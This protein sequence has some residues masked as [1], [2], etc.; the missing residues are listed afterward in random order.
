H[1]ERQPKNLCCFH[2]PTPQLSK[3]TRNDEPVSLGLAVGVT[4]Y[5]R[6]HQQILRTAWF[7]NRIVTTYAQPFCRPK[8]FMTQGRVIEIVTFT[9][10][11]PNSIQSNHGVFVENRLRHLVAGAPVASRVVAPVPWFPFSW[12]VFGTY[13]DYAKVPREELRA[14][15]RIDHPRY[16]V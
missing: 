15:L 2:L 9:T 13:A 6:N 16:T 5:S 3:H 1:K 4:K 7:Y 8:I 12:D 11:F 14:G 10:L